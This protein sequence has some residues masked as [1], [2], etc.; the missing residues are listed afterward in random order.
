MGLNKVESNYTILPLRHM[1]GHMFVEIDNE[2]WLIDTGAPISFG[3]SNCIT[4][5]SEQF[6]VDESYH[7]YTADTISHY[8]GVTCAGLIGVDFLNHF[9]VIFDTANSKLTL[10]TTELSY[11][12]ESIQMDSFMGIPIIT[13]QFG[14]CNYRMIL[15][16]G[17]QISYFLSNTLDDYPP[18]GIFKDFHFTVGLFDTK[19]YNVPMSLGDKTLSFRCGEFLPDSVS[20]ILTAASVQGIVGNEV[21]NNRIIGYY[22][23]RCALML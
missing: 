4:V 20:S 2:M 3:D 8:V 6:Y 15:D 21:F 12:G 5:G 22:P 14:A 9:D 23:R 19:T 17:A 13:V 1:H 11:D 18:A 7:S 10:S 16:T